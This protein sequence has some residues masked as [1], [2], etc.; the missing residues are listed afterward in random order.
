MSSESGYTGGASIVSEGSNQS[1]VMEVSSS[2]D[3]TKANLTVCERSAVVEHKPC[4]Q[5]VSGCALRD[6]PVAIKTQKFSNIDNAWNEG[7]FGTPGATGMGWEIDASLA[8]SRR[9]ICRGPCC[10]YYALVSVL[11]R[12]TQDDA[13]STTKKHFK[14]LC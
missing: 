12:A 7:Y 6:T 1:F 5:E 9:I 3:S 2:F 10:W 8:A 11:G 14:V 13:T 4:N